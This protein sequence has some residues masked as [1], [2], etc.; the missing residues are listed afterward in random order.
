M[1]YPDDLA[2][3]VIYYGQ[4]TDNADRLAPVSAPI[5]GLFGA[6]DR[7]VTVDAVRGFEAVLESLGKNYRIEIYPDA[8]H[9]FADA[10]G[11]NYDAEVAE[12]AWAETVAFL[13]E[14]L[15]SD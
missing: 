7:G 11:T 15:A 1:M 9:A 13:E 4:V 14:H 10:S 5:L 12:R 3:A 8:G 6:S 2:A